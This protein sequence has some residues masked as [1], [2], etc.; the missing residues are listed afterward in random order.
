MN[1]LS[2]DTSCDE[3]AVAVTND[4][5]VLSNVIWSQAS[6]HTKWGGIHPSLAQREHEKKIE[7]VIK[8]A[9]TNAK[10]PMANVSAIAV[11]VGPGLAVSL[12]VGITHAKKLAIDWQLPLVAVNHVE[13][14]I[15]SSLAESSK[16][17]RNNNL[18]FP[19]FGLVVSGGTTQLFLVE[20][21]G[22]YKIVAQT[23]DDALGEALDKAARMLGL[24]YPGGAVLE[25]M[26]K[27]GNSDF[28]ELP[29][30]MLGR[31]RERRFSYS[32][33]KTAMW[34]LTESEKQKGALSKTKIQN[35]AASFQDKAF[36]HLI[37]VT[38]YAISNHQ[39]KYEVKNLLVG[40]G[41]GANVELRKRLRKM[42]RELK[43]K[44]HFPYSKKLY[45]DNAAMIGVAAY[46]KFRRGEVVSND[47]LDSIDREP[48]AKIDKPFGFEKGFKNSL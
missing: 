41:V 8:R 29:I 21:I 13:G 35:L 43:V 2:I 18:S 23:T 7:W 26:A 27:K 32:G 15:L 10:C 31:E 16:S 22:K 28:Y 47:K 4:T 44:V 3:T 9:M 39:K 34:R 24:G 11:T 17:K 14:H 1:I 37:R 30:P 19:A 36:N 5:T 20:K 12:Q 45:T 46:F 38:D 6:L 25:K 33:L 48:R 40:G 42:A